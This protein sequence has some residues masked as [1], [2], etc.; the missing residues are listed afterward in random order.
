MKRLFSLLMLSVVLLASCSSKEGYIKEYR[1]F[2]SEVKSGYMEY[3]DEQWEEADEKFREYSEEMY[4]DFFEELN[5]EEISELNILSSVY[6]GL[7]VSVE[8]GK[9]LDELKNE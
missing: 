4:D 3:G 9:K 8:A 7:K 1:E 2:V 6:L 5:E